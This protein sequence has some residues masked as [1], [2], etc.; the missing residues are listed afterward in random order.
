MAVE[1]GQDLR[2]LAHNLVG[3]AEIA[4][5]LSVDANTI[6]V[7][8]VRHAEFPTPV[9]RLRSGDL[10]DVREI[11]AWA[12]RTGRLAVDGSETEPLVNEHDAGRP[13]G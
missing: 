12:Q 5:L 3:P 4:A 7:W 11:R 6:N 2:S 8:K 1:P 13:R 10:W 9:R